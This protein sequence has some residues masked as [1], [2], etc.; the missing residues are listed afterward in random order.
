MSNYVV[1]QD[2][3]GNRKAVYYSRWDTSK[4]HWHLINDELIGV[5]EHHDGEL[6]IYCEINGTTIDRELIETL[7]R[8][9]SAILVEDL[10]FNVD[11]FI[12][13]STYSYDKWNLVKEFYEDRYTGP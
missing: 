1:Y 5:I 8:T 12:T 13:L 11:K 2:L 9:Q 6:T 10:S 4:D 3:L 7:L